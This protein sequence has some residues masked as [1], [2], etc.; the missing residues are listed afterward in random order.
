MKADQITLV[1]P[2][3]ASHVIEAYDDEEEMME[4][5]DIIYPAAFQDEYIEAKVHKMI[6]QK[7]VRIVQN[8]QLMEINE[9]EENQIESVIFKLL[10]IPDEEEEE[11]ELEGMEQKNEDRDSKVSG[12]EGDSQDGDLEK[13]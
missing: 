11:D 5:Y 9:D 3:K 13:S 7:G 1:I 6:E 8:A 12:V 10:D 4:D 2:G